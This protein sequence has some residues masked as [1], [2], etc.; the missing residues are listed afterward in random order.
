MRASSIKRSLG[1]ELTNSIKQSRVLLVGAGGIGCELLKNLV[2]TGF[3]EIHIIDLDTIDLSNLNRQFLFRH[4]HIKKPKALV[5]KEVAHR[6]QPSAKLEAYHA[7]I[8]DSQFSVDW[9]G[10]FNIVFNALDNLAARR[11][12]NRMCLAAGVPLVES[13]TTGFNGQVQVIEKGKTECYDCNEKETP[14]SF[15]ICTIRSNPTQPIH[16]IVWA[17]N[18]L[19]PE[20]F[21]QS[22][23]NPEE[24]DTTEDADNA[25]EIEE[26]R[27]EAQA[28]NE[29]R[30]SM[31]SDDF[32]RKVFEK[33]F[34]DDIE[35]LRRVEDMW[36]ERTRPDLLD[37]DKLQEE[38]AS[39]EPTVSITDQRVWTLA[40][41][42]VVFK[43]SADRL[44]R[45]LKE[46]QAKASSEDEAPVI[47]FDKDDVDTLDFVTATANLRA[48]IFHLEAKSKFDTKQMAGN[49]IPAIA[50]TNAMTAS[51]CVLQAFKVLQDNLANA[52]MVF[53]ERSGARAINSDSLDPPKP[54]CPVCSVAQGRVSFDP[55]R[56]TL[57]DLVNVLRE[58]LGYSKEFSVI[59]GGNLIYDLDLND[60]L[61]SKLSDMGITNWAFLTVVDEDDR[62]KDPRI[63]LQLVISATPELS[64]ES[65][66][67][68][69]QSTPDIPRRPKPALIPPVEA[70]P[71]TNG[72]SVTGKRKREGEDGDGDETMTNG[73]IAKKV[74]GESSNGDDNDLIVLDDDDGAILIDD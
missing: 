63:D 70:A 42:F 41:D 15:P 26:L 5:A 73:H 44:T 19:I 48:N 20:L 74:A 59:K 22:E 7:N 39:V 47:T 67:V 29:I 38:S 35:R 52:K 32:T 57:E 1:V 23:D 62:D 54:N 56:A 27:R 60:Q 11:H 2:L 25:E 10:S 55:E 65:K 69:L 71:V 21:G 51:L 66:P 24:L 72:T 30:N 16:C 33:V 6:F 9:F 68:V 45:R 49:I 4:E 31:G 8:T 46:M 18:Y 64:E 36:K 53:L 34:R 13:G 40:E 28:L 50:T 58:E 37:Y 17:K 43:D 3:G 61:S 12:V 14:K